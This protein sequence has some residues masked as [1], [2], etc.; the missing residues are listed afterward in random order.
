MEWGEEQIGAILTITAFFD[1]F[2]ARARVDRVCL[3]VMAQTMS[4]G[5]TFLWEIKT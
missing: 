2:A 3:V 4:V 5:A 1:L